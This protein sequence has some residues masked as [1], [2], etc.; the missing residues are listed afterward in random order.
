LVAALDDRDLVCQDAW[1]DP[2][3]LRPL[4]LLLDFS[5]VRLLDFSEARLLDFSE[6]RLLD[7][8]EARVHARER[9]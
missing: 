6:A 8:S 2:G 9:F 5:E 7:F 3:G 1:G 4:G